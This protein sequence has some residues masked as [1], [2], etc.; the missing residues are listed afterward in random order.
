MED[1]RMLLL[2][3]FINKEQVFTISDRAWPKAL[4]LAPDEITL[5]TSPDKLL[6]MLKNFE[7]VR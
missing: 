3:L 7:K 2:L 5:T 1:C 6:I 4:Q